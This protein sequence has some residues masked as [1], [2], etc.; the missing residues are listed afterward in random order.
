MT[1][2]EP[3]PVTGNYFISAY[4]PFSC[5]KSESADAFR[6]RLD[7]PWRD[8]AAEPL[9]IYAHLPF[10]EHRCD[11]CYYLSH[12]DRPGE[13]D[14]YLDAVAREVELYA[15]APALEG[16]PLSFVYFGGG[17]PS[18]LS[19]A[20]I[21][22]MFEALQAAFSWDDVEEVTFECAPRTVTAQKCRL[23]RELGVT[24][25]SLGVQQLDDDVLARN[26]RVHLCRDVERAYGAIR[27]TGFDVVN[28]DLIV[29][30]I[31][32]T[33]ASFDRSLE[34]VIELAPDSVT[35]YQLEIPLSTP[36]YRSLGEN[37]DDDSPASWEV[38]RRRLGRGFER[39]E[40]A[41]YTVRSAYAAVRDP[42]RC[43]FAYQERQYRGADLLGIGASSFS[44]L[45]GVHQQ[46]LVSLKRYV[47]AL[48]DGELPLGRAY[49]LSDGERLARELILQLKLGEVDTA[50]LRSRFGVD[51]VERFADT[52]G[53]L[54]GR[55]W[56]TL[57][58]DRIV[59]TREGLLRVD[60]ML[61]ELYLPEHRGV[62]YS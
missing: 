26:G 20:R 58:D 25:A 21:R 18:L 37:G 8:R 13:M 57:S 62:R 38:K 55:G 31:G 47:G 23:L 51:P 42:E 60:R 24:R 3:E 11:Y 49:E 40:S 5:W 41:G 22:R 19:N 1:V 12:D 10:C 29:G 59:L 48:N 15:R 28:L 30:L 36:L 14:G 44:Y 52:L 53:E 50:A 35:I 32:E 27:D 6:R 34:R 43:R 17:T 39:L 16:R 46:N 4:P 54:E 61:P 56:L 2:H 7:T 45:S 33:D 9:G